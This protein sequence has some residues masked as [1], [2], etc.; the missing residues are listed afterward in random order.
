MDRKT[1]IRRVSILRREVMEKNF[2]SI[3]NRN[4]HRR[5][6]MDQIDKDLQYVR[7]AK[8]LNNISAKRKTK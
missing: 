4:H 1:D 8:R 3:V 7:L 2:F 6:I 5:C